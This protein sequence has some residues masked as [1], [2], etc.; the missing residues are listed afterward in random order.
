MALRHVVL[1]RDWKTQI[2]LSPIFSP[3]TRLRTSTPPYRVFRCGFGPRRL[4]YRDILEMS[5]YVEGNVPHLVCTAV[6]VPS[7][8]RQQPLWA[9]LTRSGAWLPS[10]SHGCSPT[11]LRNPI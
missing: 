2:S 7:A 11:Q 8:Q 10:S 4:T 9:M 1:V 6:V 5:T 3:V